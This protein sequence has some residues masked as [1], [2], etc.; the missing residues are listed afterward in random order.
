MD[1]HDNSSPPPNLAF[2]ELLRWHLRNATRSPN[3]GFRGTQWGIT[4]FGNE[5]GVSDRQVRNWLDGK[6]APREIGNIEEKLFGR[7]TN[8]RIDQRLQLRKALVAAREQERK[9]P[10]PAAPAEPAKPA[11]VSNIPISIPRHF[12]GRGEAIAAIDAALQASGGRAA[13]TA[14]HGLR[15][16]GKTVLAAA[17][18]ERGA[19]IIARRGG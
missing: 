15:G 10:Q 8:Y 1:D 13:I 3:S 2:G 7:D 12:L 4:E 6:S 9:P 18:A 16:V 19:R 5:V 17:Y 11:C 14:L